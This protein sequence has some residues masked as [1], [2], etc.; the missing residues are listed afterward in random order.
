M[1]FI[2]FKK[3]A[4]RLR[5]L[6]DWIRRVEF[7]WES[8]ATVDVAIFEKT[9]IDY[10]L[11]LCGSLQT[12]PIDITG[13]T[14]VLS[15]SILRYFLFFFLSSACFRASYYAALIRCLAPAI[16]IT[17]IDNSNL[18]YEVAR[19][20]RRYTR[21]LAIQN[22]AR[23]DVLELSPQKSRKIFIPEFA[24]FG[25][26]E[27][28][29]YLGKGARIERFYPV[30]SLRESYYRRQRSHK[31]S[32]EKKDLYDYDLCVVA[33]SS[34]GWDR[35]Y[36]GFEDAI[37]RIAQYAVRLAREK[38][39]RI[40]IA[41]KRDITPSEKRLNIHLRDTEVAWYEKYIGQEV[42]ITPRVR[43]QFTTYELISR[44]RLSLA[45]VSTALYEGAS[46]GSRVLFCN[47]SGNSLW[48]FC[49]EGLW[50]LKEDRY[51]VFAERVMHILSLSDEAYAI[52]TRDAIRFVINNDDQ[53]PTY[54]FLEKL[55]SG[56]V[57]ARA[58]KLLTKRE[59]HV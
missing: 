48:D 43:D 29:M 53:N 5:R 20:G 35:M 32:S 4:H 14:I 33:E 44:S 49:L 17:F 6:L 57:A 56:A 55:I 47:F 23:Y 1:K 45:M 10:I 30:G 25:E 34:P 36:P 59:L 11:P 3:V 38:G 7:R 12:A 37:G 54:V 31:E 15:W 28:E 27:K 58:P 24:C 13:N 42:P 26:H 19:I 41:G 40:V 46:R 2:I 21:F 9:N 16:V 50:N 18:F 52:Q 51:E 39:L 8:P 22:A